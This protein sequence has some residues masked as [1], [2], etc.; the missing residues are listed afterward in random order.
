MLGRLVEGPARTSVRS[1][2][3]DRAGEMRI[4]RFARNPAVTIEEM[5]RTAAART[6]ANVAGRHILA[7]QDTT[8]L[9]DDGVHHSIS[10]HPMVAVDAGCGA[11][12]G[13][14]S[15]SLMVRDGTGGRVPLRLRSHGE[16]QSRRWVDMT[17]EAA[18]LLAAG[19]ASVT[20]VSD[21]EADFY[22]SFALCAPGVHQLVRA[23]YDR[24]LSDGGKL[25]AQLAGQPELGRARI[26]LPAVPGRPARRMTVALRACP[27]ELR[28]PP[29]C[30]AD[31]KMLPAHF[32]V[33]AVEAVE[34][35]PPQGAKAAHWRLLTT[36]A[37]ENLAEAARIVG[38]YRDR[39]VIEQVFRTMKTRGFDIE[40][41]RVADTQPFSILC[42]AALVAAILV[43]Q[44][45]RER[46]G[47]AKRP[48][49]DGFDT[50]DL[51]MMQALCA[52][53][54]GKTQRQ[55][56]PHTPAT[57]AYVSWLCARLG[58][59]NCYY[60]KPGPIVIYNGL[61]QLRAIQRGWNLRKIV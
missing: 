20:A 38:Y 21:R 7:V 45:V 16:K 42:M 31:R 18:K 30:A 14:V 2:G 1:L 49:T 58:G 9:R 39:W 53:L 35:D 11:M 46:D 41:L 60:G 10:L 33:T 6:A 4:T 8:T 48:M 55:K 61:I 57:L 34:I 59:W 17:H 37:V 50:E 44:M 23:E 52:S 15:A 3:V 54:E 56:N 22:E 5:V 51:P 25:F 28:R 13:L 47:L 26:E 32:T 27:V 12:M 24:C 19:A 40:A 29:R 43:M 36:H